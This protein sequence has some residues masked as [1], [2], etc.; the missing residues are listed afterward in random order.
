MGRLALAAALVLVLTADA[1]A[2]LSA[3]ISAYK[4]GD[5]AIAL[6]EF[7]Q[8]AE[9][10]S[11]VAQVNLAAMY[12]KGKG[13]PRNDAEAAK[14]Y[15][16]AADQGDAVAQNNIGLMYDN[17]RGVPQD[18]GE[19]VKWYRRAA[20]QGQ[21]GAQFNLGVM[22]RNGLGIAPDPAEAAI[23]FQ[24]AAESGLAEAQYTMGRMRHLGVVL[25]RDDRRAL[26]WYR[27]AAAQGHPKAKYHAN[28]LGAAGV[29]PLP[30]S[31]DPELAPDPAAPGGTGGLSARQRYAGGAPAAPAGKRGV[32]PR[33]RYAGDAPGPPAGP[34]PK[35][36][37]AP[38]A[39]ATPAPAPPEAGAFRIQL[40]ALDSATAAEAEWRRLRRRH[41][42][43][44]EA[45][46]PR[47]QRADL[48]GKGV[49]YR[50]QAGP[51]ASAGR[52]RGLCK[53]LARRNVPCLV[54]TP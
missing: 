29:T 6:A 50:L 27:R 15:R 19:A 24:R 42:D 11:V 10:G 12:Y 41:R 47:V 39:S 32:S 7:R 54:I 20:E 52:A 37:P 9:Q 53:T 1:R 14:W 40:G 44:L 35:V 28:A 31:P 49:F 8:A 34:E 21:T 23:W 45:L 18:Y 5:Y 43:L 22:Y 51:L 36:F 26:A 16:K 30:P 33:Q 48:G 46:R 17:G 13:V 2:D 38:A 3:G 25:V 4:R